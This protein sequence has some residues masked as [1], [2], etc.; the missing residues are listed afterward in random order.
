MYRFLSLEESIMV[1]DHKKT[2]FEEVLSSNGNIY[3]IMKNVPIG[4]TF[5]EYPTGKIT[6]ANDR[7]IE[8][9]G[10]N[11]VGLE[12]KDESTKLFTL[13]R[14][15]GEPYPTKDLP[16]RRAMEGNN[17]INEELIIERHTDGSR[18]TVSVTSVSL[19]DDNG[20]IVGAVDVLEDISLVKQN[21]MLVQLASIGKT[22]GMVGHDIRNPL[23]AIIGDVYLLKDHL[24][25]NP[26]F[27][28]RGEVAESL[29]AI[30]KNI[31]YVDKIVSDLQD[32]SRQ[33]EPDYVDFDLYDLVI[34]VFQPFAIPDNLAPSI[35]ID[36][37]FRFK[38]DPKVLGRILTNLIINAI[39]AMP[40]G[41]KLIVT[42]CL[43]EAEVYI[44]V[45]DTGVGIP[46][47]FKPNLFTPM[48][49]TKA[50]GQG[51]GLAV[52]K[53]LVEALG[54]K[55]TFESEEGKGA[56]FI[57]RLPSSNSKLLMDV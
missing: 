28:M 48:I 12:N 29:D 8:L 37:S 25:A 55:I 1:A 46:E 32:Y 7:A 20:L 54:G 21:E 57:I 50:K 23:Q 5:F 38:S 14:V 49:T 3:A 35:D 9:Y 33:V 42:G 24:A 15:N 39:Q 47:T 17:V 30:E 45:E 44:T 18:I 31:G 13:Y 51:L 40:N 27:K 16:A 34:S 52:V 26:Q 41:G 36:P 10:V 19:L 4:I 53:R 43:K 6:Y 56:K 2:L 11:P 22:A